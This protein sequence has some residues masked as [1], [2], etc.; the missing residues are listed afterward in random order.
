MQAGIREVATMT[1]KGQVTLPKSIRQLLGVETGARLA[2]ELRGSEVVLSR[3]EA[4]HDD[5]AIGA[6][7]DLLERDIRA[8][9]NVGHLPDQLARHMLANTMHAIEADEAIEGEVSL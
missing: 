2:F 8:G 9:A 4:A 5:P 3:L 6:F 1:S 7:L